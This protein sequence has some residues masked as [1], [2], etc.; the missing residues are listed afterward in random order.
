[1]TYDKETRAEEMETELREDKIRENSNEQDDGDFQSWKD[2]HK[3]E[4]QSEFLRGFDF[5]DSE[6]FKEF[7]KDSWKEQKF[8]S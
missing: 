7:C 6:E 1:M 3:E 5:D 2:E 8:N 4:L